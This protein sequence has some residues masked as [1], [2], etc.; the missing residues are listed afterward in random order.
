MSN[1]DYDWL[2][3]KLTFMYKVKPLKSILK[4]IIIF[5]ICN[6]MGDISNINMWIA[7]VNYKPLFIFM[8]LAQGI[9]GQYQAPHGKLVRLTWARCVAIFINMVTEENES[10]NNLV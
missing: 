5:V 8:P 6:Y 10:V 3:L 1:I 4:S 2:T 9:V 7:Y